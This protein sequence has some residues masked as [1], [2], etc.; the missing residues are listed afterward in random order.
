MFGRPFDDAMDTGLRAVMYSVDRIA[1]DETLYRVASATSYVLD[2][3]CVRT[4]KI[5][6]CDE[7]QPASAS[8][9]ITRAD[10]TRVEREPWSCVPGT[11]PCRTSRW[12]GSA[13]P[14]ATQAR[15]S[16]TNDHLAG[17]RPAEESAAVGLRHVP[18]RDGHRD[19]I[20]DQDGQSPRQGYGTGD[21]G[22]RS[23]LPRCERGRLNGVID[24]RE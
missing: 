16:E 15:T 13:R 2:G 24:R 18:T 8:W 17:L 21:R 22:N 7:L 20:D 23:A 1:L 9:V 3:K 4:A 12:P 10:G 6:H 5:L 14:R 19:P 11:P